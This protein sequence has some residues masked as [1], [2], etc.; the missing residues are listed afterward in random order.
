MKK[1]TILLTMAAALI[2]AQAQQTNLMPIITTGTTTNTAFTSAYIW[3]T[4]AGITNQPYTASNP[5]Y[6]TIGDTFPVAFNK[7]NSNEQWLAAGIA[8]NTAAIAANTNTV[9]VQQFSNSVLSSHYFTMFQSNY[10]V[11]NSP[12]VGSAGSSNYLGSFSQLESWSIITPYVGSVGTSLG[13][14]AIENLYGSTNAGSSWFLIATSPI[15]PAT[16]KLFVPTYA[17]EIYCLERK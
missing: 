11:F 6:L 1:L 13:T 16:K 12:W 9:Q 2:S 7:V 15:N 14:N 3:I 8:S 17:N 5:M 10:F 4:G